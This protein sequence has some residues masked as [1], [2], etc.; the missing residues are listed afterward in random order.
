[1][2]S[3]K[4]HIRD[5]IIF[6]LSILGVATLY[7]LSMRSRG[8]L[9]RVMCFH[10]VEDAGW[11]RSVIELFVSEFHVITPEEFN[12]NTFESKKI[13]ILITFDD[14]YQSWIDNCL[15]ALADYDIKAL[16]FINSGLLDAAFNEI[17]S[18][19]YYKERVLI[20]PK[21]PLT[22]EGAQQL[23]AQGHS[24]GGHTVHHVNL[25]SLTDEEATI[26]IGEDKERHEEML[27]T[28]LNDFAYPFGTRKH[29]KEQTIEIAKKLGYCR[30][31]S[32]ITGFVDQVATEPI[33]RTLIEKD[34]AIP[35]IRRWIN[36]GDEIF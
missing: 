2:E 18:S 29:F 14:G 19:A 23:L 15:P 13:N 22:W 32:A 31:Y 30:Q 10:D 33:P 24:I 12:S 28:E 8:P 9:V 16:F 3:M 35:A 20:T 7:R 25:A 17:D 1:M 27:K 34:Q 5:I 11:F 21:K 26:E 6:L 4:H 36:G